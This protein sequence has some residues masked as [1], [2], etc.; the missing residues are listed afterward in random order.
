MGCRSEDFSD[1][2]VL[3]EVSGPRRRKISAIHNAN[4]SERLQ[5]FGSDSD[6]ETR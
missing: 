1:K 2:E 5:T 6:C 3:P 4:R